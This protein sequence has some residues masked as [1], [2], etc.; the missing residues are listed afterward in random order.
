M[1]PSKEWE[2]MF[3]RKEWR[4]EF[5]WIDFKFH[6]IVDIRDGEDKLYDVSTR[7]VSSFTPDFL[8]EDGQFDNRQYCVCLIKTVFELSFTDFPKFLR[9]QSAAMESPIDW[10]WDFDELLMINEHF[11]LIQPFKQR[12]E[13]MRRIISEEC[14]L[15]SDK[16]P[17]KDYD[18]L[19]DAVVV[20]EPQDVYYLDK[21]AKKLEETDNYKVHI[22]KLKEYRSAYL[23]KVKNPSESSLFIRLVDKSIETREEIVKKTPNR[24][25][26]KGTAK[27]LAEYHVLNNISRDNRGRF[28]VRPRPAI[29]ARLICE[30]YMNAKGNDFSFTTIQKAV[31]KVIRK[32][33]AEFEGED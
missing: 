8:K 26:W 19:Y 29:E 14:I 2:E 30:R 33:I 18:L 27:S 22:S 24:N 25:I 3:T 20:N 23:K 31:G 10:L 4:F 32:H 28:I 5:L 17:V 21:M 1:L 16:L 12:F 7:G 11:S 6:F 13:W 9:Y 15:I